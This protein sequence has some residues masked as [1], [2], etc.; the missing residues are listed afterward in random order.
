MVVHDETTRGL[1][2]E[3]ELCSKPEK[4]KKKTIMLKREVVISLSR[5]GPSSSS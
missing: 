1:Q 3:A 5:G 4:E 2:S